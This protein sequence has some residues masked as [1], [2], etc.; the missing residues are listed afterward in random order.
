MT[1]LSKITLALA[2][3][4]AALALTGVAASAGPDDNAQIRS[5]SSD[6]IANS[7]GAGGNLVTLW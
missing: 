7:G 6:S 4:I 1:M 5:S 3:V 2:L